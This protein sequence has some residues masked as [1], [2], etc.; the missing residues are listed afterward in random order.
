MSAPHTFHRRMRGGSRRPL[1]ADEQV[2]QAA[3]RDDDRADLDIDLLLHRVA[4]PVSGTAVR[5]SAPLAVGAGRAGWPPGGGD[6]EPVT[7]AIAH[8]LAFPNSV[9]VTSPSQPLGVTATPTTQAPP[10]PPPTT[11]AAPPPPPTANSVYYK[12]CD[13]VRAAGAAPLYRGQPGYARH[14]DRDND[15]IACE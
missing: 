9:G 6:V 4:G 14:L 13:A 11:Q 8:S 15:G 1:G 5:Q 10:P 7:V 12:N 3:H 2:A